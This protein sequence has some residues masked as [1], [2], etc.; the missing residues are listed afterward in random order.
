M[1]SKV[2]CFVYVDDRLL[3][4]PKVQWIEEKIKRLQG[5]G[6]TLEIEDSVAGFLGVHIER[7]QS[8]GL[9]KLTQ[10]GLICGNERFVTVSRI[11]DR[12][13]TIHHSK[14]SAFSYISD[15]SP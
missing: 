13:I 1:S 15:Y 6:M 14:W 9:I 4:S 2:I 10:V 8:D 3:W 5:N 7:N 12:T 11:V